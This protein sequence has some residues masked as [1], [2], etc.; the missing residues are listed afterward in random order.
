MQFL[1]NVQVRPAFRAVPPRHIYASRTRLAAL[2][3]SHTRSSYIFRIS[4]VLQQRRAVASLVSGRPASQT[5]SQAAVNVREE[6]GNSTTDWAKVI[7]GGNSTADAIKVD[8]ESFVSRLRS[9][10][11][12]SHSAEVKFLG[13]AWYYKCRRLF[14]AQAIRGLWTTRRS[15]ILSCVGHN[16]LSSSTGWP[17]YGR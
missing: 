8:R 11:A 17:R 7:A 3:S 14:R 6:V 1:R 12:S 9:G 2:T 5:I 13:T 15:P 10:E 16:H 4:N